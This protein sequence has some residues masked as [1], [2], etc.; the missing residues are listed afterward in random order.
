MSD[1]ASKNFVALSSVS[2]KL[3]IHHAPT[4]LLCK[5]HTVEALD[6]SNLQVLAHNEK[7][8]KLRDSFIQINPHLR[9]FYRGR[10]TVVVGGIN[11]LLKLVTP[12]LSANSVS[13]ADEFDHLVEREGKVKHMSLYHERRFAKLGYAAASLLHAYD[14]LKKLLMETAA[15]NL[16]VQVCRMYLE[17]EVFYTELKALAY[18]THKITLPLV[19]CVASG[20]QDDLL[21]IFPTLWK[22]LKNGQDSTLKK[23]EVI[24]KHVPV[25]SPS[26]IYEEK[27]LKLMFED[28]AKTIFSTTLAFYV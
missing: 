4:H 8:V 5:A 26:N 6:K 17:T 28:A 20:C 1:A 25:A 2:R 15:N 9:S 16:L 24:Y 10:S 12:D 11:A 18:F 23:W 7:D 27:I 21:Q 22:D 3:S 19:N 14:L 13:L